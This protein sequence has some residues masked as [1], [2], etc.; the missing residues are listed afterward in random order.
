[1]TLDDSIRLEDNRDLR[2][3]RSI[4]SGLQTLL[5]KEVSSDELIE[6]LKR[7]LK[8]LEWLV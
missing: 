8:E 5:Q 6:R 4:I 1:M 3:A 7:D 2:R